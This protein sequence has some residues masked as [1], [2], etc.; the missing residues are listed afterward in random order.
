MRKVRERC[1]SV[2]MLQSVLESKEACWPQ[3]RNHH[4]MAHTPESWLSSGE[5]L[6]HVSAG[7]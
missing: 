3:T 7:R 5:V 4:L 6:S 1:R 2:G